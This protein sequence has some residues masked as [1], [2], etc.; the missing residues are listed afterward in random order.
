[1][2]RIQTFT[3]AANTFS[4]ALNTA[5][6]E[7]LEWLDRHREIELI[8]VAP[9]IMLDETNQEGRYTYII[10]IAYSANRNNG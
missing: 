4:M 5:E 2:Y 3:H 10:T 1:M 8:S 6:R 7:L 9:N